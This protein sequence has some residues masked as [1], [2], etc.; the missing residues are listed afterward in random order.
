MAIVADKPPVVGNQF[1][2]SSLNVQGPSEGTGPVQAVAPISRPPRSWFTPST[3]PGKPKVLAD[4]KKD[5]W[6]NPLFRDVF[7]YRPGPN[8]IQVV[9][10]FDKVALVD[11]FPSFENGAFK[12]LSLQNCALTYYPQAKGPKEAG[13]YFQTDL[14][15][16]GVLDG[17]LDFFK[18]FLDQSYI[19]IRLSAFLGF[20]LK[21]EKPLRWDKIVLSG[22][23]AGVKI[24]YPPTLIL[25]EV[26]SAGMRITFVNEKPAPKRKAEDDEASDRPAKQRAAQGG[27][28][29]PTA[30]TGDSQSI[31]APPSGTTSAGGNS[32]LVRKRGRKRV[33]EPQHAK[34][35]IS[36]E[37]FGNLLLFVGDGSIV[38][39]QLEYTAQYTA[40]NIHFD[41]VLSRHKTWKDAFGIENCEVCK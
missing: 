40:E 10:I 26:I 11:F 4:E 37:L 32:E 25:L 6:A 2:P 31:Q 1:A 30:S 23:L 39:L 21:P 38:P 13:L 24:C 29:I 3:T 9:E 5:Y 33:I 15:L 8:D 36:V 34:R 16:G 22:C 35:G 18:M 7:G 19:I 28:K 20:E 12:D 41:M 27:A 14:V 17:V